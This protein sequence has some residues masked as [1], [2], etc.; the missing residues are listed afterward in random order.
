MER[1]LQHYIKQDTA[2]H[3]KGKRQKPV[4][5]SAPH[6]QERS[7]YGNAAHHRDR[8]EST[9]KRYYGDQRRIGMGMKPRGNL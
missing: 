8:A 9:N 3:G 7:D 1:V 4:P 5:M 6:Q 2:R